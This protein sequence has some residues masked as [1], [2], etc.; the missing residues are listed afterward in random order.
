MRGHLETWRLKFTGVTGRDGAASPRAH[1]PCFNQ[2]DGPV[3]MRRQPLGNLW[4]FAMGLA[5]RSNTAPPAMSRVLRLFACSPF[6]R[7]L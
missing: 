1:R 7:H 5:A 2:N 4:R 6:W 3:G